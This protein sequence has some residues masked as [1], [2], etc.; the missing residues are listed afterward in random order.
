M[1]SGSRLAVLGGMF[2]G[3][4]TLVTILTLRRERLPRDR[5]T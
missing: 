5:R 1:R 2:F 3:A 4:A